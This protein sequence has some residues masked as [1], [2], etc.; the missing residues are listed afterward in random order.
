MI[1]KSNW[2]TSL[3]EIEYSLYIQN[4]QNSLLFLALKNG[5]DPE[6]YYI[7]HN[8]RKKNKTFLKKFSKI[9]KFKQLSEHFKIST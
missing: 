9:K 3:A 7:K 1:L 2:N 4:S 8:V 6:N 5:T